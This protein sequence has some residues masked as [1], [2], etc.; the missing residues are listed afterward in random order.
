VSSTPAPGPPGGRERSDALVVFGISGDLAF[1]QIIPALQALVRSGQLDYPV[2]GVALE[3]WD[4]PA[5]ARRVRESLAAQGDVDEPT[6]ARLVALLRYVGGD[7]QQP[8][9]FRRLAEALQGARRPLFY[10][11]IPPSMFAT[12]VEGLAGAGFSRGARIVVEKPF[13]RDLRSARELNAILRRQFPEEAIFRIDHY[14]GKE[15]V[16]N[17]LYFRFANAFLEPLWN[18]DRVSSVQITMGER[19]G[20]AGRGRFYEETGALRDVVQNHLLQ[21]VAL[22]AMDPP[23]AHVA[24]AVRDEKVRLLRAVRPL[25][26]GDVV[27]GQYRG[28]QEE[29]G[30]AAGSSVETYAALR[31]AIETWRWE[32]V[33]FAIR[34][35]KR[36]P[37]TVAEVRVT[38][39]R[40]PYDVF[41]EGWGG[42]P[43]YVRFRI[44]PEVI[45]GLGARVKRPGEEMR[46]SPVELDAFY[47]PGGE[48]T[49]YE[50]LLGDAAEGDAM[51][52]AREDGVEAQWRIVDPVLGDV[53]P[54]LPYEPGTWGPV[55]AERLLTGDER[56]H[57]PQPGAPREPK[58]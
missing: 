9:T 37:Q 7:Y 39:R 8:A 47:Q 15:P 49:P 30:V 41:G 35:G 22:L 57:D 52:F 12:V 58:P 54:L 16:Q 24:E 48:M 18:R 27:R 13:G 4:L 56:W 32:G 11:A 19:F 46:G 55:E 42:H 10:L 31:L 14:L 53:A 2:V 28:Y 21:I 40:P 50:R 44:Q 43:N 33:P 5:V 1:K 23:T 26:A 20:V 45:L 36:L 34:A 6:F 29:P 3:D 51:L 25:S 38:L 17:L